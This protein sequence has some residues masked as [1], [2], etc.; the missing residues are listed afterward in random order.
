[1]HNE[2]KDIKKFFGLIIILLSLVII[3]TI[4]SG[5]EA[6]NKPE[7]DSEIQG[8]YALMVKGN[9]ISLKAKD[10]SLKDILEEIGRRM[11]IKVVANIPRGEKITIDFDM[12][13]LGDAIKRFRTNYA[14]I[15]ASEKEKGK[16]SKIVAVPEGE[17]KALPDNFGYH[18]QPPIQKNEQDSQASD[19]GSEY[20][21][22]PSTVK[23]EQDTQPSIQ[24]FEQDPHRSRVK[25]NPDSQPFTFKPE[26]DS[27]PSDVGSEYD[28]QPSDVG[29]EYD[30][31]PSIIEE[32]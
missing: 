32:K 4:L 11:N 2:M 30:P 18:P 15:T 16:I 17:G 1:M 6:D 7:R 28:S 12:M 9:Q 20:D 8:S 23:S 14:Y 24:E 10:A 13:Y 31:Q 3:P 26:Q 19:V 21:P 29:S 22:Q 27:Q 5:G 25:S